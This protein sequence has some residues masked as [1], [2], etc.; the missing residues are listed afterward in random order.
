[1]QMAL[2]SPQT[3]QQQNRA[4]YMEFLYEL[5]DRKNA[6][7]GLVGTFTGL[8]QHHCEQISERAV[9]LQQRDWHHSGH[10]VRR[11]LGLD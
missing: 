2:T 3:Q 6:E 9:Q 8:Y 10:I 11:N 1:M 5:Y 7:P 4:D